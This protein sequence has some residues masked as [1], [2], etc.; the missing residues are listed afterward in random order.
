MRGTASAMRSRLA[1]FWCQNWLAILTGIFWGSLGAW[2]VLDVLAG[3][4]RSGGADVILAVG[5]TV[6]S[7]AWGYVLC[8]HR[9]REPMRKVVTEIRDGQVRILDKLDEQNPPASQRPNLRL[10]RRG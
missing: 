6:A 4:P 3:K 10:L 9:R 7:I 5:W 8:W 1:D 2:G